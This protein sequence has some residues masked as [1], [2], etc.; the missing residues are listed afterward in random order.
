MSNCPCGSAKDFKDC[1]AII[2]SAPHLAVH[3][4]QIMRARYSAFSLGEVGFIIDTYHSSANAQSERAQITHATQLSWVKLEIVDAPTFAA[5]DECSYVEF[6]A[7]FVEEGKLQCLHERSRFKKERRGQHFQWC[8]IDGVH[9]SA[10]NTAKK[11]GRNSP[12]PCNSGKKFK[13]CCGEN[14]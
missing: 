5:T 3:A 11:M 2:H 9:S 7:W 4:Q 1:C 13:K 8:Y 14:N 12:C 10:Q 6:K